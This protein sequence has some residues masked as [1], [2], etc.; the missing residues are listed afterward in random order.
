MNNIVQNAY[1][2]CKTTSFSTGN[3]INTKGSEE[4]KSAA[5]RP[6]QQSE[7]ANVTFNFPSPKVTTEQNTVN[8]LSLRLVS[9]TK[10]SPKELLFGLSNGY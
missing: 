2:L 4:E 5:S 10:L 3:P 1:F 9:A 8:A 6:S 7:D